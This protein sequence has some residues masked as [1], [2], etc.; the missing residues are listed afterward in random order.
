MS[1]DGKI[2]GGIQAGEGGNKNK[3]IEEGGLATANQ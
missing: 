1:P 3:E 2:L